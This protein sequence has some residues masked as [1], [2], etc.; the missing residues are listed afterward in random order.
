MKLLTDEEKQEFIRRCKHLAAAHGE[1]VR[2]MDA[3]YYYKPWSDVVIVYSRITEQLTVRMRL[4][5]RKFQN[6]HWS[7]IVDTYYKQARWG[8]VHRVRKFN[9]RLQKL[10]VLEDLADV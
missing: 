4:P 8:Y 3:R 1:L 5:N 10:M 9:A 7:T 6:E 2:Y